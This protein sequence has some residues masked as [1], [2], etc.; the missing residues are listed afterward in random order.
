MA[1]FALNTLKAKTAAVMYDKGNDYKSVWPSSSG[2]VREG[3]GQVV[4]MDSYSKDD[5]RLL[6]RLDQDRIEQP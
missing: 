6:C 5:V 4:S 2:I 1:K 3:G